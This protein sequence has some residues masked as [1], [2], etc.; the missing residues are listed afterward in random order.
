MQLNLQRLKAV[1]CSIDWNLPQW[2]ILDQMFSLVKDSQLWTS[3][4]RI[5]R[6]ERQD[7][8]S[9]VESIKGTPVFWFE[10]DV[11]GPRRY[12]SIDY[13]GLVGLSSF[14]LNSRTAI[15]TEGVSDFLTMKMCYPKDNILG[16]TTL[17]GNIKSTKILLT[18]ADK[19]IFI[20]DNDSGKQ[21][22]TGVL[23]V[24]HL[25]ELYE[26][27]G[28]EVHLGVPESPYKDVTEKVFDTLKRSL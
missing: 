10:R 9:L 3:S 19:L 28:K 27:Y 14:N 22:N 4:F 20:G 6:F 2:V 7:A 26:S 25:K 24:M 13:Y 21:R 18:L 5:G 12:T 1:S 11:V 17:G 16:F 15:L 23:N 8:V